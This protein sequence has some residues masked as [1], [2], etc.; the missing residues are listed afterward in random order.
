MDGDVLSGGPL[1][2][3]LGLLLAFAAVFGPFAA[4]AAWLA[5]AEAVG[6]WVVF[7]PLAAAAL[8]GLAFLLKL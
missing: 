5:L 8:G 7:A 1:K 4:A 6:D 2:V 3:A